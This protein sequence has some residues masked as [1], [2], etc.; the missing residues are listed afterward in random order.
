VSGLN[1]I[2]FLSIEKESILD[3]CA[4]SLRRFKRYLRAR[5][6]ISVRA[7]SRPRVGKPH[8]PTSAPK[9]IKE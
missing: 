6:H 2:V 8:W 1:Q 9:V 5:T 7:R 3:Y 4:A